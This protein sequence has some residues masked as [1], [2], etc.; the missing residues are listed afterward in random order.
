MKLR[1]QYL[2]LCRHYGSFA[3]SAPLEAIEVTTGELAEVLDCTPRT[4]ITLIGRMQEKGWLTWQPKR[5]RANRSELTFHVPLTRAAVEEAEELAERND[6]FAAIELLRSFQ[7]DTSSL[8]R[9]WLTRQFGVQTVR[10][11]QRRS[12][13]LRFPLPQTLHSLDPARIHFT[14]ESHLVQQL[15]DGL[16]QCDSKGGLHPH[17]AHAWEADEA[18]TSWTFYLRKGVRFHHGRE[19]TSADVRYTLE[20]LLA[21]APHGLFNWVY[22]GIKRI[23]TPDAYSVQIELEQ[24]NEL[25]P[26]FLASSRASIVPMDRCE[27]LGLS[28]GEQPVGTGPYRLV[29]RAGQ[30]WILDAFA[31]YFQ[32]RGFLDRIEVWSIAEEHVEQARET[33][34][35]FQLMH[36]VRLP[37]REAGSWQ[38]IRQ[39]GMTCKFLT[40]PHKP[41][42]AL[43]SVADRIRFRRLLNRERLLALLDG[44]VVDGVDSFWPIRTMGE[45]AMP[46]LDRGDDRL[47]DSL[48]KGNA[49]TASPLPP[50]TLITIPE[51]ERDARLVARVCAESGIE[52]KLQ[53]LAAEEFNTDKRFEADLLLFAVTLDEQRELRLID[54]F[55]SICEHADDPLRRELR[56]LM[57]DIR[58]EA[59]SEGRI[60][61]FLE[62][63]ELLDQR[64]SLFFLYRKSLKT[65]FHPSI[66]GVTLE[67][68]GWVRFRDIWFTDKKEW[69]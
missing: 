26:S 68:L 20:R 49:S 19:L 59:D 4:I 16:I 8:S 35:P 3:E 21:L 38:E 43:V 33:M 57:S 15:F 40:A 24:P 47:E 66:R 37:D 23:E 13:M 58:H 39:T 17:L 9:E 53:L 36:N 56:Q 69:S 29:E 2:E 6:L 34:P 18:R 55:T 32:G 42:G 46:Y 27:E 44:D 45:G 12:D 61:R 1:K 30:V 11:G 25:F 22:R 10:R 5:G 50:L 54:L 64:S 41:G 31:D 65:A 60:D 48:E 67:S 62:I 51:Y 28:F 14:G 52:I 63:E 7:L